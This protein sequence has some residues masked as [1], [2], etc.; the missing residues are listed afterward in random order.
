MVDASPVP[1]PRR[2]RR[3]ALYAALLLGL[4]YAAL[5]TV[6]W[7]R[8]YQ[9][10][11]AH[12][13]FAG[14]PLVFAHRGGDGGR[15]H[16]SAAYETAIARGADALELDVRLSADGI[17]VVAHDASLARVW[18]VDRDVAALTVAEMREVAEGEPPLLLDEVLL[19]F[20]GTRLNI[21]L[22]EDSPRLADAV[23]AAV[24]ASG[25]EQE[26]LVVSFHD[27]A[28]DRFRARAPGVATGASG[29]EAIGFYLCYLLEVPCRPAYQALQVPRRLGDGR[30]SLEPGSRAF[31][32]FAHRHGL[33]VHY[34]TIDEPRTMKQ[35]LER[36]ADGLITNRTEIAA[37][38]VREVRP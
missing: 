16:S 2:W 13:F 15:E 4:L 36:G 35:L 26:V 34:W 30:L 23:A 20:P 29:R 9:P 11:A 1:R 37:R 32:D 19:R 10:V 27:D 8:P 38:A 21:E 12:P 18:G 14:S 25:R 33:A 17:A 5:W 7:V 3:R 22:K 31:L 6:R 28:L 24:T